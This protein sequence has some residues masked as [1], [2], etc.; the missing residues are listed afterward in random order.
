MAPLP[1]VAP[2]VLPHGETVRESAVTR[3]WEQTE[4]EADPTRAYKQK[5]RRIAVKDA[6]L[7]CLED[8]E[9]RGIEVSPVCSVKGK[10]SAKA[11]EA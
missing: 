11:L 6:I 5:T 9:A 8:E 7:V 1:Q 10:K 3:S 4:F 2:C